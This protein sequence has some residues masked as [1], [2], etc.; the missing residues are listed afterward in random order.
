MKLLYLLL[1]LCL[2][3]ALISTPLRADSVKP[4]ICPCPRNY[5]PVCASNM[6]TYPNRCEYN[7][8]RREFERTGRNLDLL[9]SGSC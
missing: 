1:T 9:R 4:H 7:C 8:A 5:D 2:V 6:A 3:L